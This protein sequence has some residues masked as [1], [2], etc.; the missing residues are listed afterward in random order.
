MLPQPQITIRSSY[1][2]GVYTLTFDTVEGAEKYQIVK[3]GTVIGYTTEGA[4]TDTE[5]KL[6][7]DS[8]YTVRSYVNGCCRGDD[9]KVTISTIGDENGDGVTDIADVVALIGK[10]TSGEKEA[11]LMQ[12]VRLIASLVK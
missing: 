3:N 9:V 6:G 12:I 2:S 8:T 11:T 7:D 1:D 10:V 5:S 4:F